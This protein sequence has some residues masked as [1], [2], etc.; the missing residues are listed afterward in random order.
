MMM[1][2]LRDFAG[3][4]AIF[5]GSVIVCW[6]VF[7]THDY[8]I[9]MTSSADSLGILDFS[10]DVLRGEPLGAW[11]LPRAPY[12]FPDALIASLVIFLG[13]SNNFS[14]ITIASI[15]YSLLIIAC[16]FT[17]Q[18]AYGLKRIS[19]P[20]VGFAV[21]LSLLAITYVFP[22][23]V[24]NVYWQI[25]TSG[26]HF[27]IVVVIAIMLPLN[28][29]LFKTGNAL[30]RT[31]FLSFLSIAAV[32]SNAMAF[33]L[34]MLWIVSELFSAAWSR[35]RGRIDLMVVFI[36]ALIGIGLSSIIPRQSLTDSFF[37]IEKF[38]RAFH[39]FY[40]W[41]SGSFDNAVFILS[42]V[43]SAVAFTYLMQGRWPKSSANTEQRFLGNDFA[44]QALGIIAISPMFFEAA[45]SLRYLIFPAFILILCLVLIY[46]RL[47]GLVKSNRL[48]ISILF[49]WF[50]L[51]C[52][53]FF[54]IYDK[55]KTESAYELN[56]AKS[57]QCIKRASLEY[58]LQDGI[59]SYWNARPVKFYSNFEYYLAQVSPWHPAEGYFFWGNN[60]YEFL[61][62]NTSTKLP[63]K[64]NYIFATNDEI[65]S[66][67]WGD[68]INKSK[69]KVPCG[70]NTL[71]Y[72]DDT[73]ILWDFLFFR[74]PLPSLG[75][76]NIGAS[77][78]LPCITNSAS[79]TFV[80]N[81]AKLFTQVG[82]REDGVIKAKGHPGYLVFGPYIPLEIGTYR[83][84]AKG[85]LTGS[86]K[87]LGTIDVATD[88]GQHILMT[89][90]IIAEE[91]HS[92][93]GNIISLDFE[94]AQ[95]ATA[96]EFRINIQAQTMGS[97]AAYTLTKINP[98]NQNSQ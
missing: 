81:N 90:P 83:L 3:L 79:C 32:A 56:A 77:L 50:L 92:A 82:V 75:N 66:G 68:V 48:R 40:G 69:N 64:Y 23:S 22:V 84:V 26:S 24:Y 13:W 28:K 34:L 18:S 73:Q 65:Q 63:R 6:W 97:F 61:Y 47:A 45:G 38:L 11:N 27:G 87:E 2:Y 42:L 43:I 16:Y 58:P 54:F 41:F 62:K 21:T 15:N 76:L 7:H 31:L 72:F 9:E 67:I 19:L 80:G 71:F 5:G 78:G 35:P 44:L 96:V 57:Y 51:L 70:T 86:S 49:L 30:P 25:F 94:V 53:S 55:S 37:S 12:L 14:I 60:W 46:C 17:L 36:S 91:P 85:N 29:L 95:P 59:A 74:G 8:L 39:N 10:R 20:S 93:S 89:K 98:Q 52:S 4:L 1:K 88:A 33:L